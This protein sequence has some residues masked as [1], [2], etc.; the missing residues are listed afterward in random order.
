MG[1][2][3]F[4]RCLYEREDGDIR[5]PEDGFLKGPLL[6]RVSLLRTPP[7]FLV[8]FDLGISPYLYITIFCDQR[9]CYRDH[10]QAT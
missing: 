4:L 3:F 8:E 1:S 5:Y 10:Q 2:H 7:R 9:G 6:V